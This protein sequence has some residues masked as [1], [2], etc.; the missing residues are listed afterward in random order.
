MIVTAIVFHYCWFQGFV[1]E[2]R[3]VDTC[4]LEMQQ[5]SN[6][7]TTVY[8]AAD[9]PWGERIHSFV[10][11]RYHQLIFSIMTVKTSIAAYC[12]HFF[13]QQHI[14]TVFSYYFTPLKII[15]N[16]L[17]KTANDDCLTTKDTPRFTSL[18]LNC[19]STG[20]MGLFWISRIKNNWKNKAEVYV[21]IISV[22]FLVCVKANW[23]LCDN[24]G[25][26]NDAMLITIKT[27]T[28]RSVYWYSSW[29]DTAEN[30]NHKY[31]QKLI[32]K[33]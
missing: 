9:K 1:G 13:I 4:V 25:L 23:I 12:L 18:P 5:K 19:V 24:R 15:H 27:I 8:N 29:L 33:S 14:L 26:A 21:C 17:T 22:K 3:C 11:F 28:E 2:G 32:L 7:C 30:A 10:L 16:P 6:F 20:R 31:Y